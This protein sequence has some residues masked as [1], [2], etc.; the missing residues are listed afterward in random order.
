MTHM[1]AV[2]ETFIDS[3]FPSLKPGTD[4]SFFDFPT[5]NPQYAGAVTGGAD[6]AVMFNDTPAARS[7]MQFMAIGNAWAPWAKAGG[8]SSPNK[9]FDPS[10]YPDPVAAQAAAQLTNAK[11]F[12]F[13]ADDPMPAQLESAMWAGLLDY[14]RN[15]SQLDSILQNLENEA[16][17]DYRS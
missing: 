8:Y 17:K 3:Q 11:I 6:M 5:I 1:Q 2:A 4:Y 10:N 13:G 9:S 14:V 12:R 16:K 7:F 15:P